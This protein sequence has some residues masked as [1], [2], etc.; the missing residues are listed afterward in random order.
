MANQTVEPKSDL[1]QEACPTCGCADD[2]NTLRAE[3]LKRD[4]TSRLNRVEGQ[5]R[6]IKSMVERDAYCDDV[7]NQIAAAQAALEAISKLLLKNHIQGCVVQKIQDGDT[8]IVDELLITIGK[9]L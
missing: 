9:M 8:E 2:R 5:I 4:L 1:I 6:G 3:K 7:L